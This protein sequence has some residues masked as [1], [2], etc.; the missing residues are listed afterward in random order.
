M[1]GTLDNANTMN[2][3]TSSSSDSTNNNS[4]RYPRQIQKDPASAGSGP[5][6]IFLDMSGAAGCLVIVVVAS[7]C[8]RPCCCQC[9]SRLAVFCCCVFCLAF[10]FCGRCCL[11]CF[12][13]CS[14]CCCCCFC[15]GQCRAVL[16][17]KTDTFFFPNFW[18][19]CA[20][21]CAFFL[22]VSVYVFLCTFFGQ[23]R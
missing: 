14:C 22:C 2:T 7:R 19:A 9:R 12:C 18:G 11:V 5:D 13:G 15:Y 20:N 16:S 21:P 6:R 3:C 1:Q 4:A 8:C 23:H 17:S 10:L